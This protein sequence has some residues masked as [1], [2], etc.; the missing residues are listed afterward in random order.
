MTYILLAP[1]RIPWGRLDQVL[2]GR[3]GYRGMGGTRALSCD[4]IAV[5][6]RVELTGRARY[7]DGRVVDKA[8]YGGSG[9][10]AAF[11]CIVV[12]DLPG[13]VGDSGGPVF[14]DAQ[15][16][17]ITSQLIGG[18]LGFTPLAEGLHA[19]GLTLCTTPDCDLALAPGSATPAP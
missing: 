3:T 5:G 19:L 8:R 13:I 6:A 7:R 15:P 11:P 1:D 16:A 17:G 10:G 9:G 4:D 12:T 14:V 2:M 18:Q